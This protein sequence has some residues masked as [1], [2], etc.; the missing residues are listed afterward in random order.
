MTLLLCRFLEEGFPE[1]FPS[2]LLSAVEGH[3]LWL[4]SPLATLSS[5]V[6]QTRG[7]LRAGLGLSPLSVT[8]VE[9]EI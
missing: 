6:L 3:V 9:E 7:F 5:P 1:I 4:H 2:I 8:P